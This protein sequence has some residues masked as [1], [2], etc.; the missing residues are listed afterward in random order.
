M[1]EPITDAALTLAKELTV[2]GLVAMHIAVAAAFG[3]LETAAE[4]LL[5]GVCL[6]DRFIFPSTSLTSHLFLLENAK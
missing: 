4:G 2:L 1:T 5:G 6:M 3:I